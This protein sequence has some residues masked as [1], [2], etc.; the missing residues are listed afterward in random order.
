[1][2][3]EASSV[4]QEALRLTPDNASVNANLGAAYHL[5]GREEDAAAAFQRSLEIRPQPQG[6]SNLGTLLY[7][8]GRYQESSS[9]FEKAVALDGNTFT[10]WGNLADAYRWSPGMRSKAAEAYQRA[11]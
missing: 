5:A 10:R 8:L 4:Y 7:Y 6:F 3:P 11:I 2:Y 1:R 9:A